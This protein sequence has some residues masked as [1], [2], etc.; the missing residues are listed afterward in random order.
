MVNRTLIKENVENIYLVNWEAIS[1][2]SEDSPDVKV[3]VA[4]FFNIKIKNI[5]DFLVINFNLKGHR[6]EKNAK[7]VVYMVFI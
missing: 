4:A 7:V 3:V 6:L 5:L 1:Q 2:V